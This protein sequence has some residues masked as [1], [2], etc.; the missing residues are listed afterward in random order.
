MFPRRRPRGGT[1]SE[2]LEPYTLEFLHHACPRGHYDPMHSIDAVSSKMLSGSSKKRTP[3]SRKASVL[4]H[5]V[6]VEMPGV[7]IQGDVEALTP[8]IRQAKPCKLG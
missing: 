5:D 6:Y 8:G 7:L 2:N 1:A 3:N 4:L